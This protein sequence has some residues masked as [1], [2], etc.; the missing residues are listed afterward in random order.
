MHIGTGK[1]GSTSL[2]LFCRDNRDR[3]GELGL[4]YPKSPGNARHGRLSMSLKTEDELAITPAWDRLQQPDPTRLRRTLRRRLRNE[5]E[6]SGLPRVL[7]SDEEVFGLSAPALRRLAGLAGRLADQLRVVVYLRRQDD[8]MVSRYQQGVK[9]GWVARLEEFARQDMAGL[10]NYDERLRRHERLVA[11]TELVV[12][13]FEQSSF[14]DGSLYQDFLDAVGVPA[15][16]ADLAQVPRRN[17]SLDA[18]SVEF[19]R[20]LNLYRVEHEGARVGLI[21]NRQLTRRLAEV[22]HGPTLTLP[23]PVL[24]Q[25]MARWEKPNRAVARRHFAD[26]D[27]L[28]RT[29]R[30][31]RGTTT[32]QRL[33]HARLDHFLEVAE[34]PR[35]VHAPL[36]QLARREASGRST[37]S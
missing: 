11:P 16:A 33:D 9:I 22:S 6:R 27:E 5:I 28:F 31:S 34:M 13:R 2:Q 19:L 20:L 10:Y 36:R 30:K 25:F 14:S 37:R 12:R 21:D 1:A 24:D 3:L 23:G 18:E 32:T 35:E 17:E 29:P 26:A 15:R 4:L 8:H 7:L